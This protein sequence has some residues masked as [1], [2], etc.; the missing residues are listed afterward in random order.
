MSQPNIPLFAAAVLIWLPKGERPDP[1]ILASSKVVPPPNPNPE[2]WWNLRDAV[3]YL[4]ELQEKHG[5]LPWIK[6]GQELM[7][8]EEILEIYQLGSFAR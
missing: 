2:P 3:I 8:P 6:W 5:K 4:V 1:Q 7:S